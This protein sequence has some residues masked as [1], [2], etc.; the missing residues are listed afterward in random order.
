MPGTLLKVAVLTLIVNAITYSS[1]WA[2]G[3]VRT[4]REFVG[5]YLITNFEEDGSID[6]RSLITFW[7]DGNFTFIDSNQ[8]GVSGVFNPFT[9][10]AGSW[11]CSRNERR[12]RSAT[13]VTLDFTLPGTVNTDQQIARL[14]FFDVTVNKITGKI[15]GSAKLRFFPFDSNPL[16]PPDIIEDPFFF[17]G[18]RV[19]A[20][21]MRNSKS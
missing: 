20:V 6:S 15:Q 5:T 3:R 16:A 9:E 8:G 17:E 11:T 10:A 7:K 12:E 14:D 1:V 18:E 4:C 13:M 21:P 19:T 2:D